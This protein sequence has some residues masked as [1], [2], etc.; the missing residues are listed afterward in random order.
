MLMFLV[1]KCR[2]TNSLIFGEKMKKLLLIISIT[3]IFSTSANAGFWG[4]M[5]DTKTLFGK[6]NSGSTHYSTNVDAT[7]EEEKIQQVLAKLGFYSNK[8]DGNLNSFDTRSAIEDFQL[9]YNL[10]DTGTLSQIQKQDLLYMHDLLKNYKLELKNPKVKDT[11]RLKKIYRAFDKLERK[12]S[13]NKLSKKYLSFQFK[14]EIKIRKVEIAKAKK[15]QAIR[16]AKAKKNL[17]FADSRTKLIWQDD[18]NAKKIRK[19]WITQANYDAGNYMHT[20]GDTAILYCKN[21]SLAGKIDWR[22]PTKNELKNLYKKKSMLINL[23]SDNYWS[24]TTYENAKR[25]VWI[26]DFYD[27]RVDEYSKNGNYYVRC[28]R[29]GQ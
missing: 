25:N 6:N 23:N 4:F 26:V 19:P 11:K 27:G 28:V 2:L 1:L 7:T 12:L 21:L 8:F 17:I 18:V 10:K 3:L 16:E 20:E 9:H 24:S 29:A 15:E 22:L 5:A 14:K 13:K